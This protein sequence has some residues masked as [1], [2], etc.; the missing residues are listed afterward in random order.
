MLRGERRKPK[1]AKCLGEAESS[2]VAKVSQGT[3]RL[4]LTEASVGKDQ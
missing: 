1:D 2:A 4:V 3:S